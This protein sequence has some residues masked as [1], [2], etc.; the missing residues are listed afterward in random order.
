MPLPRVALRLSLLRERGFARVVRRRDALQT[1]FV[2]P[3]QGDRGHVV[4]AVV[5]H[6]REHVRDRGFDR[7][8][9]GL[10]G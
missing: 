3:G 9:Q 5:D 4:P 1:G 2:G 6:H 8:G 7:P 10:R